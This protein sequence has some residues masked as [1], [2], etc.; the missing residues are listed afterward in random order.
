LKFGIPDLDLT[1]ASG[2]KINPSNFAGHHLI[3]LFCPDDPEQAAGEMNLYRHHCA[4]FV[5]HDAWLLAFG[6]E[7]EA[8]TVNGPARIL[9]V[10]DP[11][12]RAWTAFRDLTDY[13]E[14]FEWGGGAVFL[15]TSGGNLHR[16]WHGPGHV[17]DV[18]DQ[19]RDP[20]NE[21]Q[22]PLAT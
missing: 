19:L 13:P 22:D 8:T 11:G 18:L 20:L 15:F 21:D 2:V 12:R 7:R 16:Y 10:P 14:A 6:D 17:H 9:T 5:E 1:S 4:D 3:V